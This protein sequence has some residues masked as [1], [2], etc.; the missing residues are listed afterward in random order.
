MLLLWAS[1]LACP[2]RHDAREGDSDLRTLTIHKNH[3][4]VIQFLSFSF[5]KNLPEAVPTSL[6][7]DIP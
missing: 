3:T 6:F 2:N 5:P 7:Q 1:F 4:Y